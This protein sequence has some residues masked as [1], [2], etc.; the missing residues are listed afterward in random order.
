MTHIIIAGKTGR[1]AQMLLKEALNRTQCNALGLGRNDNYNFVPGDVFID[2]THADALDAN[3]ERLEGGATPYLVGTTGFN[4]SAMERLKA[5]GRHR[6]VLYAPNTS[7]VI[8]VMRQILQ[9]LSPVMQG[10]DCAIEEVHHIHKKD[11]PSGTALALKDSLGVYGQNVV[12]D[13]KREGDE[14]GF[15]KVTFS[16]PY[17]TFTLSHQAHDRQLFAKGAIDAAFW[18]L[19]QPPGF[20]T[21][22]D[23]IQNKK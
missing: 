22:G 6:P 2:F 7:M 12:I 23:A 4:Q 14:I 1:M 17:E 10:Y 11:S 16:N 15:H 8:T 18:L 5:Q 21:M 9:T 19:K 3:I 13:S 20:Y